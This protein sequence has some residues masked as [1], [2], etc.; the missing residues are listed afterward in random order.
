MKILHLS[1]NDRQGGAARAAYRL[2]EGLR[3]I[4]EES[5][6]LVEARSSDDPAVITTERPMDLRSRL[7]R[8]IREYRIVRDFRRYR[9]S[10]PPGYDTF[11]D[12][13]AGLTRTLL[14]Q[15]PASDVIN[16]H[17]VSDFLDHVS[18]FNEMSGIRPLVWTLHGMNPFTGGCHYNL[19]CEHYL[20]ACKACPQLGSSDENDLS[21][22]I[23]RRKT[24]M[25]RR[26]K[27]TDLHVV[28][29]SRW[30]AA[31]ARRS[32][33]LSP[34]AVSV[35]PNGLDVEETFVP[36]EQA[37]IRDVLGIPRSA[38]V[39]LFLAEATD[40]PRKGFSLL[41]EALQ[42]CAG[43]VPDLFL[44][45]VGNNSPRADISVPWLH[46]GP[47]DNDRFLSLVYNAAD[48][49]S[50]CSVQDNMPNTVLEAVAC[51]VPVVGTDVGGI[52][53]M[54]RPGITGFTVPLGDADALASA[55]SRVLNDRALGKEM[56]A[57]CRRVAVNEYSLDLQARRYVELYR[58]LV[59]RFP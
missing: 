25:Y 5:L 26:M 12:D 34:F 10:R 4:G 41:T 59:E 53:D 7:T 45:S 2:H 44:V 18:F 57:A 11:S 3:H 9:H 1:K 39:V 17:W 48:V 14:A 40:S 28:A 56:S 31:E 50:I 37:P 27:A 21:A 46:L 58:E 6:M 29:P 54:V 33:L 15:I 49:F 22:D 8:G 20:Q 36:R 19:G 55:I 35:I 51:G 16:L 30:L 38:R 52:P 24:R 43:K 32:P 23:W 13:R 47:V 42:L